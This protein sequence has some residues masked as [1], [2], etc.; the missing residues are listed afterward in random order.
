MASVEVEEG[1]NRTADPVRL[2]NGII[3]RDGAELSCEETVPHSRKSHS[4]MRHGFA[5]RGI[6]YVPGAFP[7]PAVRWAW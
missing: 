6:Q 2:V 1:D 7:D 5:S 4:T 3:S